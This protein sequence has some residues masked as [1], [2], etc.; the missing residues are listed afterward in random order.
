MDYPKDN[1]D[2]NAEKLGEELRRYAGVT[3]AKMS[4]EDIKKIIEDAAVA[5]K[6]KQAKRAAVIKKQ[7]DKIEDAASTAGNSNEEGVELRELKPKGGRK[8]KRR[9]RPKTRRTKTR[10][11]KTRRTKTRRTKTRRT[12][13]R[14]TKKN[15]LSRTLL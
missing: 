2:S 9:R 8:T 10:R 15:K 5:D 11:T 4:E 1:K 12:K 7:G 14:R 6:Q 13:T 3:G